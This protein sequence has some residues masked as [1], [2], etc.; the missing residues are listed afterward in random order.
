ML[1]VFDVGNTNIKLGLF[2]GEELVMIAR[3][4]TVESKTGDELALE[5]KGI[6]E[7]YGFDVN[8]VEGTI[9]SSVVPQ[10]LTNLKRAVKLLFRME[11]LV[12]G[13]GL[14]TGINLK[15]DN[16]ASAGADLVTGCVGAAEL[17]KLPCI[18]ISMGTA[19]AIF[20]IDENKSMI[21]GAIVPGV[22]T[23][24]NA[25][26]KEGALLPSVGI[27]APEK[28]VGKNTDE[29]MRSGIVIGTAAMIDGMIDRMEEETGFK[30]SL[31]ATG[32]LASE[33]IPSCK[34]KIELRDD[35]MLQGLRLIYE[36]N[37]K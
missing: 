21:G 35:L 1:L 34:H 37:V 18:A 26:I 33:I 5:I 28:V 29:C 8:K 13:P 22:G 4:S 15:I 32:G 11:P 7:V 6:F 9:I 3:T 24:L 30:C 20:V 16:P 25:L 14:K 10:V 27:T 2:E 17:Y 36:K 19:T 12:V 31:V 23:S